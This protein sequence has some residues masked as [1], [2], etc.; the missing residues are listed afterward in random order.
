MHLLFKGTAG[1]TTSMIQEWFTNHRKY[2]HFLRQIA[3][4]MEQLKA[5]HLDWLRTEPYTRGELGGWVSKKY[6][7]FARVYQ[8]A[9][10][11]LHTI[12]LEPPYVHPERSQRQW[13]KK[14]KRS[15]C[16]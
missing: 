6:G 14:E 10:S 7:A 12:E 9:Y 16:W 11:G 4:M 1:T 15:G 3:G 2:E 8:W 5:L 13:N